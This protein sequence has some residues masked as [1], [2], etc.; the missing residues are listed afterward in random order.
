VTKP[1]DMRDE[2]P[3]GRIA[4]YLGDGCAGAHADLRLCFQGARNCGLRIVTVSREPAGAPAGGP[5]LERLIARMEAG[6]FDAIVT[7]A[8]AKVAPSTLPRP[9][10]H[11]DAWI[12]HLA[13]GRR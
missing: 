11:G 3:K 12:T 4:L 1:C 10:V 7:V 8:A 6:E 13:E 5:V 9:K 2:P